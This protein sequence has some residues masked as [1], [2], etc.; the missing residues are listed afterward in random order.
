MELEDAEIKQMF[1]DFIGKAKKKFRFKLW[2]FTVM[3]KPYPT[4]RDICG[5]RDFAETSLGIR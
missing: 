3:S 1:L 5:E 2:N 4:P